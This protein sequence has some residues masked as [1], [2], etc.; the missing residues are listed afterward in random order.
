MLYQA[1]LCY[2]PVV[3]SRSVVTPWLRHS[4]GCREVVLEWFRASLRCSW[5]VPY[6]YAKRLCTGQR[7]SEPL[8]NY[9]PG[10]TTYQNKTYHNDIGYTGFGTFFLKMNSGASATPNRVMGM[11]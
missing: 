2:S 4:D 8:Q 3:P 7:D 1:S 11:I 6:R 9:R 10:G 5:T